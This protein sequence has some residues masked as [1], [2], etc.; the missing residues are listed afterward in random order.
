[1]VSENK[2]EII[3]DIATYF[4]ESI[5]NILLKL[6]LRVKNGLSE[7]RLRSARPLSLSVDGANVFLSNSGNI[8]HLFQHGLYIVGEKELSEVFKNICEYSEYAYSDQIRQGFITLKNG[9]RVGLAAS[10]VYENGKITNLV[11]ISSLNIRIAVEYIDCAKPIVSYLSKG[12]L[13]AGP[14]SSGK[15][16]VLRDAVR[17]ISNGI[18]T[19]RRRVAVVDSRGEIAAVKNSVPQMDIGPLTDVITGCTKQDGIEMAIRTLS[20]E[21]IAFDEIGSV[22]E[23]DAVIKSF[24]SGADTI[25]TVHTGNVSELLDNEVARLVLNSGAINRVVFLESAGA[26]PKVYKVINSKEDFRLEALE[27]SVVNA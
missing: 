3:N 11:H 20:P 10:A 13:I 25:C 17:L 21:V 6:P 15:T 27:R 8:C 18:C 24:Y 16:T 4:P 23:A 2:E 7:I 26:C 5:K 1:M 9:C 22:S 12:L 19:K 14:P